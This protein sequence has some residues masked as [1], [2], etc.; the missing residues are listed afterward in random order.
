MSLEKK[1]ITKE[2]EDI[3][4]ILTQEASP[5]ED[6]VQTKT[7]IGINAELHEELKLLLVELNTLIM[8]QSI[9]D[10]LN[11]NVLLRALETYN[12]SVSQDPN[13]CQASV[14]TEISAL[15]STL[16]S[17]VH[18]RPDVQMEQLLDVL[19][20]AQ[21]YKVEHHSDNTFIENVDLKPIADELDILIAEEVAEEITKEEVDFN[22]ELLDTTAIE[23]SIDSIENTIIPTEEYE[24]RSF[25]DDFIMADANME[26]SLEEVNTAQMNGENIIER[27]QAIFITDKQQHLPSIELLD[28]P[29]RFSYTCS[30]E[31]LEEKSRLIE[32]ILKD[33]KINVEVVAAHQGPVI[34]LFEM[35]LSPGLKVSKIT[36][37]A[38]DLARSLLVVSVRVVEVIEGLSTVG[39][40]IPNK[41]RQTVYLSD[42]FNSSAFNGQDEH[43][44]LVLG[45]DISGK[46]VVTDLMKMP[47]LL[48]A[49]T[50]GSGKSVGVN[51]MIL[52]LLFKATP[53]QL[54]M[55][56]IDPK[57]LE[58]SIYEGIPHLLAPVVTDMKEA[59]NALRWSVLEMERRYKLMSKMGV[60]NLDGFNKKIL[61]AK[62]QGQAIKDPFF[63]PNLLLDDLVAPDLETMPFI[64]IIIDEFAD[65]MM[66][67]GKKVEELI[68][69]LAQKARA[70][71]I[72][73][74]LA[75]QR[76]SVDVITGLIKAN[77]PTR[78]AFQVS[79]KIDSRTILDQMGA[80][81]LLGNGDMLYLPPG[82]G[83]PKRIHGAFVSDDEVHRVVDDLKSHG[84]AHYIDAIL[85]NDSSE[86]IAGISGETQNEMDPLYDEAVSIVTESR[87]A[88]ISGVQRRLKVGYNRAARMIEDMELAGVVSA[89]MN[90]GQ[91]EVLAP[92]PI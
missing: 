39:L 38:K 20:I 70:A 73:L 26:N 3:V 22:L 48:V 52:S 78:M 86:T 27:K 11:L 76:P 59:S 61:Q 4:N 8:T 50:T 46:A 16:N 12:Y 82:S 60:R 23:P 71:G 29:K 69:R 9:G 14:Q 80:E 33:Y 45:Q 51:A 54:R 90:N 6:I 37:L 57:M 55:I 7:S 31:E 81:Q 85:N 1:L 53:D 32:S 75:T 58:L 34:T 56:M 36:N 67:V 64:V 21:N 18:S 30:N 25:F 88:S 89:P 2:L 44:P 92:P 41:K 24:E 62:G 74:V 63:E 65:M 47:H 79:T 42:V 87:K 40:E 83:L 66:I 68:A 49:G 84:T 13:Y 43:L 17:E 35:Q 77:I 10:S 28:R 5:N 19:M 15:V 72:H 91:R